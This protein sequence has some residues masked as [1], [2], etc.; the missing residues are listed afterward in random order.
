V[1]LLFV[2]SVATFKGVPALL[3]SLDQLEGLPIELR[4]V[5]PNAASIPQR[6]ATDRRVKWIGSVSRSDV[7][8][9]YRD[10]DVLMFPSH[11]DGFGMAQVE[12]QGWKLPVIA[13]RSCGRVIEDGVSGLVLP[14]VSAE[15]IAGA[16]REVLK[17]ALLARFA[18]AAGRSG[19]TLDDF[20]AALAGLIAND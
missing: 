17:P 10:A 16:V 13:S 9:H 3:E 18:G 4:M 7:M 20:G 15:A 6:F 11:S 14:E 19:T 12:A 5:G 8:G 1:R 2:G